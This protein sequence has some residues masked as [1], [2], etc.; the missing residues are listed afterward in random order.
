M[1]RATHFWRLST[2]SAIQ[3]AKN[4]IIFVE[5]MLKKSQFTLYNE[6]CTSP[7]LI[8]ISSKYI[9]SFLE[10]EFF[11]RVK[12][13]DWGS[14]GKLSLVFVFNSIIKRKINPKSRLSEIGEVSIL[15]R[16]NSLSSLIGDFQTVKL[17]F[18]RIKNRHAFIRTW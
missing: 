15:N 17:R 9:L 5:Y 13:V 11:N 18:Y 4:F 16:R 10:S 14:W 2:R 8:E 6:A 3:I 1:D 12:K 7:N